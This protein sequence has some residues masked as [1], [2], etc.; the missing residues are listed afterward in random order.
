M[1]SR[2]AGFQGRVAL[3]TGGSRGI[4]HATA[5]AFLERGARVAICATNA[6]RLREAERRLRL[7]G[8]ILAVP[9]DVREFRRS[10]QLRDA[11]INHFGRIDV[12]VNNAGVVASG[13]FIGQSQAQIDTVVDTNL[14]G[15]IYVTRAVLPHFVERRDGVVVNVASGA[16]LNG[17]AGLAVYCASKFGLVGFSES[18]ALEAAEHGVRVYAVCPGRVATDMQQQYSGRRIGMPPERVAAEIVRLVADT[19]GIRTGRCVEISS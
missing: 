10:E 16:G 4:G 5:R 15:A 6:A 7:L 19:A 18:L 9:S 11:V 13:P 14:K 3:I 2:P 8:E 12:L 1:R 17:F